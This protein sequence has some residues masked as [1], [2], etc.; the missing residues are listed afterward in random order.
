MESDGEDPDEEHVARTADYT[1][2]DIEIISNFS[3]L[4]VLEIGYRKMLILELYTAP[5]NGRYPVFFNSFPLL[6][7]LSIVTCQYL[8]WDL[9]MLAGLPLLK[10]LHCGNNKCLTGNI[11]SLRVLKSTLEKVEIS[12]S[13]HVEGNFIDLADFPHLKILDLYKTA[14]TGDIRDIGEDDFS[15]LEQ[16]NLPEGV[17]GGTGYEFQRISDGTKLVRAVYL[18]KQRSP[19]KMRGWYGKL[20]RDSPD[21]YES[22]DVFRPSPQEPPF[23]ICLVQAGSRIGY[24]WKTLVRGGNACEVNWLDPEPNRE[25]SDYDDYIEAIHKFNGE[26]G[27][28]RGFH[29]PPT[30]EEYRRLVEE[31]RLQRRNTVD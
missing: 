7:R 31:D 6:Q 27:M 12:W 20:S 28:Y 11:N 24:R 13:E 14:V 18:L 29:Q 5:L 26:I 23:Y 30:E 10:E 2:H 1:T 25:N 22:V 17:Y 3:K 9:E 21:R 15:P 19:L 8:N 4:R 16:L